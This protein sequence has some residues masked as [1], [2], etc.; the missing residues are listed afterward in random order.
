MCII[1]ALYYF[2]M[3]FFKKSKERI[4]KLFLEIILIVLFAIGVGLTFLDFYFPICDL[5][6]IMFMV[7]HIRLL[8]R[9]FLRTSTMV[10]KI[11]EIILLQV[12]TLLLM[13]YL[14]AVITYGKTYRAK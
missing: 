8:K 7:V 11:R 1:S 2:K 14:I 5:I 10:W 3:K 4:V 13:S 9:T 12:V 6:Y